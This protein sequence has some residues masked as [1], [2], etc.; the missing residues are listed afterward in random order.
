M[1]LEVYS[2]FQCPACAPSPRSTEPLLRETYVVKGTLR[3]VYK[4]AAFQGARAATRTTTSRSRRLPPPAAPASRASSGTY[5][6]WLFANWD[7]ENEGAFRAERLQ[8]IADA[9]RS[10]SRRLGR[11]RRLGHGAG[12]R[13]LGD[14]GG[15]RGAASSSRRPSNHQRPGH[16]GRRHLHAS[17]CRSSRPRRPLRRPRRSPCPAASRPRRRRRRRARSRGTATPAAASQRASRLALAIVVLAAVGLAIAGYLLAV[18]LAGGV[19]A[20]APAAAARPSRPASTR[21]CSASPS[22]PSA[23][24]SRRSCS[25]PGSSGGAARIDGRS[26]R[27]RARHP[28]Q[29]FVAYLTYL[30]LFVIRAICIWCVA[31]G[32]TVVA[33]FVVAAIALRRARTAEGQPS[34]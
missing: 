7:G 16:R 5:P 26:R 22:R 4:D 20:A 32:T 14:R 18:R 3:I 27:L 25:P 15:G 19:P 29:L 31:Y 24:P 21:S 1:T 6:D 10:R 28:R 12:G 9:D 13:P 17:S 8:A 33:G 11:L 23:S 34:G 30:E 2:D